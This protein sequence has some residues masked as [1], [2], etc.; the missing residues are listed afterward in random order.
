MRVSPLSSG[1]TE[2]LSAE[3]K[4]VSEV[5]AVDEQGSPGSNGERAPH[6]SEEPHHS[7]GDGALIRG[8]L[9]LRDTVESMRPPS[10]NLLRQKPFESEEKPPS[11][12]FATKVLEVEREVRRLTEH[13]R[14]V[15][16]QE[17]PSEAQAL[18]RASRDAFLEL[19]ARPVVS[20]QAPQGA[21]PGS[22]DAA[23][24][25]T[26]R[27]ELVYERVSDELDRVV[28]ALLSNRKDLPPG[29]LLNVEA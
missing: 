13:H 11:P 27:F 12:R 1:T 18:E 28:E 5:Q 21:R 29:G 24:E 7:E 14:E 19:A 10:D 26:S 8:L 20:S 25:T 2:A 4:R 23:E 15:L 17:V 9:E 3:S 6:H 22:E 16:E